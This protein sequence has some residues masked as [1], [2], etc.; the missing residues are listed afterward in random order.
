MTNYHPFPG[1][2]VHCNYNEWQIQIAEVEIAKKHYQPSFQ[3]FECKYA[4][5]RPNWLNEPAPRNI[6]GKFVH[7][8]KRHASTENGSHYGSSAATGHIIDRYI[9]IGQSC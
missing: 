3:P 6:W 5:G 1:L 7:L 9:T 8:V 4:F 2:Y